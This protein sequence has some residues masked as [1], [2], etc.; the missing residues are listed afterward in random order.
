MGKTD[1]HIILLLRKYIH[2]K[3]SSEELRELLL[4]LR[5]SEHD[6]NYQQ[7]HF[8][9]GIRWKRM[10]SCRREEEYWNRKLRTY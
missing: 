8:L 7:K 10:R 4:W 6:K 5:D 9:F 1:L 2:E 3:C